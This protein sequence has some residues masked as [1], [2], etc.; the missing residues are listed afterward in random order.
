MAGNAPDFR[1][2]RL[3]IEE[4]NTDYTE[5]LDRGDLERWVEFFTEDAVYRVLAAENAERGLPAGLVYCEGK[6]MLKDRAF[7]ILNTAMFAPRRFRHFVSNTKVLSL[8]ADGAILARS[9][10]LLLETLVDGRTRIHQAG[11]YRDAFVGSPD[12]LLL[13]ARDCVYDTAMVATSLVYPV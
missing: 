3:A 1:T 5:T 10:Y 2:L 9:N 12:R 13:R 11:Q 4:F 7:A 6:G 8:E